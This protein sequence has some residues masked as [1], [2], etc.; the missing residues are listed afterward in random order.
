MT[1]KDFQPFK[2]VEDEGF[3][4]FV[5]ELNPSY[6]IPNRHTL[7]K[8]HIPALYQKCLIEMKDLVKMG[9]CKWLPHYRLLD[10]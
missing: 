2:I 9:S 8:V 4:N 6:K 5:Q 1:I 10:F 7:S 3:K